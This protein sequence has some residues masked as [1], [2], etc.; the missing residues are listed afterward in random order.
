MLE[1]EANLGHPVLSGLLFWL[2]HQ[3]A[4][5]EGATLHPAEGHQ[6]KTAVFKAAVNLL[7]ER[8]GIDLSPP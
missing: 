5:K 4:T 1:G 3:P 6:E 8:R 2:A 7:K